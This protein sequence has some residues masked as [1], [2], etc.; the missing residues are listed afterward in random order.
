[1]AGWETIDDDMDDIL[2]SAVKAKKAKR[3]RRLEADKKPKTRPSRLLLLSSN[4]LLFLFSSAEAVLLLISFSVAAFKGRD[5]IAG[6]EQ[7]LPF[8]GAAVA[9]AWVSIK[10]QRSS[11]DAVATSILFRL[12]SAI[13]LVFSMCILVSA[14]VGAFTGEY[15]KIFVSPA[16]VP[17]M[18]HKI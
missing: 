6:A 7:I 9:Y 15:I 13:S 8:I 1:M 14:L 2:L 12:L 11:P 18:V 3:H 4:V 17:G 16:S 10:M 5:W